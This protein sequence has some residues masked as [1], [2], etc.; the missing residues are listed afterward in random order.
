[1]VCGRARGGGAGSSSEAVRGE[2]KRTRAAR[3]VDRVH[4]HA[5]CV[6]AGAAAQACQGVGCKAGGEVCAP[7][8]SRQRYC[9]G[10]GRPSTSC[11]PPAAQAGRVSS[12][13][14]PWSDDDARQQQQQRRRQQ[15]ARGLPEEL[16]VGDRGLWRSASRVVGCRPCAH[17][18]AHSAG[19][20]FTRA[21]RRGRRR[22]WRA[23]LQKRDSSAQGRDDFLRAGRR[24]RPLGAPPSHLQTDGRPLHVLAGA[25]AREQHTNINTI[26]PITSE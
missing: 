15:H 23:P 9:R 22:L 5:C 4:A 10:N 20:G 16:P 2:E 19:Q 14:S 24:G 6:R 25:A 18:H 1:M 7:R 21:R 3:V 17:A 12:P 13:L 11:P 26:H 8:W